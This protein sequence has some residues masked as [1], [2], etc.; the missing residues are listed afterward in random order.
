MNHTLECLERQQA[1]EAWR[2]RWPNYCR[3]CN[4][5]GQTVFYQSVPYGATVAYEP[6][7]DP[8]D[9]ALGDQCARCGKPDALD[10]EGEGPCIFC[11]WNYDEGTPSVDCCCW[12][13]ETA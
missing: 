8:C 11:G 2:E 10:E 6:I 12:Q 4:G 7:T 9:C 5:W 13:G 1:A 3:S